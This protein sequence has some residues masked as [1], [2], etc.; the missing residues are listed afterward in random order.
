MQ[1]SILKNSICQ[2]F[3]FENTK[4]NLKIFFKKKQTFAVW[5]KSKAHSLNPVF[6]NSYWNNPISNKR[7]SYS[8]KRSLK[9][10]L[11]H[12]LI[13]KRHK[14]LCHN[15]ILENLCSNNPKRKFKLKKKRPLNNFVHR[16]IRKR[17]KL[18]AII[19]F[20]KIHVG[21]IQFWKQDNSSWKKVL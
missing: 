18:T 10:I 4:S 2:K 13:Q 12:R 20:W 5:S 6:E 17:P 19:Q 16:L 15:P 14:G 11:V 3:D 7:N 1:I 21:T 9:E 8:K